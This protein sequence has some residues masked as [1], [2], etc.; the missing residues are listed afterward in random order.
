[1]SSC[2]SK[3][4]DDCL[5]AIKQD[6]KEAVES[7]LDN[8]LQM[9]SVAHAYSSKRECSLQGSTY[10]IMPEI[11]LR[12]IF[13]GVVCA[14]INLLEK[15]MKNIL[16]EKEIAELPDDKTD[17]YKR[18]MTDRYTDRP[19]FEIIDNLCYAEFLKLY[20]LVPKAEENDCQPGELNDEI[21]E[22]KHRFA[23]KYP[24]ILNTNSKKSLKVNLVLRYN[25]HLKFSKFLKLKFLK[26]H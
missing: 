18:N 12:K 25:D 20:Q 11:W 24:R 1:M 22:N 10:H 7:N 14:N 3:Q 21:I 9:K 17:H 23:G 2:L 8:Y 6:V 4:E 16:S 19:S 15:H 5:Q 13:P 26:V